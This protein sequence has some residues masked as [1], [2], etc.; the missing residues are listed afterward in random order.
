MRFVS[1]EEISLELL[2]E[3][4]PGQGQGLGLVISIGIARE[5]GGDLRVSTRPEGGAEFVL[6]LQLSP[7][8]PHA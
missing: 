5:L 1:L 3:K 6:T 2:T 4:E 8:G 7:R